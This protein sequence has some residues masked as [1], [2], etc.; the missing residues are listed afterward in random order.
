MKKLLTQIVPCVFLVALLTACGHTHSPA[1]GWELNAKEHWQS[2]ECGET[3]NTAAHTLDE[4]SVCTACG[5][6][7][8]DFGDFVDVSTYSEYGDPL[9]MTSYDANGGV[10]S[11]MRYEYEYDADGNKLSHKYYGDGVLMEEAVYEAGE[12]VQYT[13]YY[14]DGTKN[15]SEYDEDGNVVSTVFYDA[16]GTVSSTTESEYAYTADGESYE[17]K[18]TMTDFEGA[19]YIGEYNEQGDQ[20]AWIYYDAEGNLVTEE[21][22]EFEYDEEG[23]LRAKR[24]YVDGALTEELLYTT[25]IYGNGWMSYPSTVIDYASDGSKTV[26]EY[27][28]NDEI[29]SVTT[30]DAAGNEIAAG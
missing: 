9:R 29:V 21:R 14:E 15:V 7:I 2:C 23:D 27:D 8:Q 26:T 3:L 17:A 22:Y 10:T 19:K 25:V 4:S 13:S 24:T 1:D 28:E 30:Y 20:T 18:N 16:D 6:E 11:D 12:P 5:A